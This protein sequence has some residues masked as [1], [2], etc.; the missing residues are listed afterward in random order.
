MDEKEYT[1]LWVDDNFEDL[2][3]IRQKAIDSKINL[4]CFDNAESANLDLDDNFKSYD[5]VILDGLFYDKNNE[6]GDVTS[7]RGLMKVVNKLKSFENQKKLPWFILTGKEVIKSENDF[8]TAQNKEDDVHDKLDSQQVQRLFEKIKIAADSQIDSQIIFL[9]KNAFLI[10]DNHLGD[11]HKINLLKILKTLLS[12][13]SNLYFDEYN[14]IRAIIEL[15]FRKLQDSGIVC[16]DLTSLNGVSAFLSQKNNRYEY[17]DEIIHPFIGELLFR[18]LN[19]TQDGSHEKPELKLRVQEYSK[20]FPAKYAY[21]STV[22]SLLE[23]LEYFNKF[24]SENQDTEK[25]K[26]KWLKKGLNGEI[27]RILHG[28]G[29][30]QLTDGTDLTVIP[31]MMEKY[32]L[33]LGQKISVILEENKKNY[34]QEILI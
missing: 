4:V 20:K 23:I 26:N 6:S 5:A 27:I 19:I 10:Y 16:P 11:E 12:T 8:I 25:N 3:S 24:L 1:V 14:S 33:K 2:Y 21:S 7:Q 13:E 30:L 28:Y 34:I 32:S 29:T 18:T 22:N 9:Y 15:L 31:A 17:F